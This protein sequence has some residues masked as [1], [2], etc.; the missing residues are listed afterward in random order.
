M[1]TRHSAGEPI[2]FVSYYA[3]SVSYRRGVIRREGDV[4][5]TKRR[6]L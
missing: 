5:R 6:R 4:R 2:R 3:E 1:V